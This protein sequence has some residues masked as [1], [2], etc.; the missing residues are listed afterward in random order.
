VGIGVRDVGQVG[1][2]LCKVSIDARSVGILPIRILSSATR[3]IILHA[4]GVAF[5]CCMR[6]NVIDS[7]VSCVCS[8]LLFF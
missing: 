3:H 4:C 6:Q 5:A 8:D 1:V 2:E 7:Q